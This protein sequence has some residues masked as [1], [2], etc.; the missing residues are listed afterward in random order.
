MWALSL[1]EEHA[2][3][4][5]HDLLAMTYSFENVAILSAKGATFSVFCGVLVKM[6]V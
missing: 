2:Y 3:N 1:L 5:C 6:K 4:G